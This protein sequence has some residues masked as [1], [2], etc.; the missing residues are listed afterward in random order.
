MRLL[1]L[2]LVAAITTAC[3]KEASVAAAIHAQFEQSGAR[4][5]DLASAVPAPWQRVCIIGPYMDN[6]QTRATLG[7]AWDSEQVSDIAGNEGK[8]L[9]AFVGDAGDV[10]F[11]TDY[12][13]RHGDFSNL[14]GKCHAR[15]HADFEYVARP[16]HGWPGLF[17]KTA[18]R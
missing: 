8:V 15:S 13:R 4:S 14:A 6:A 16:R 11:H 10:A 2:A 9:L 5:I 7:F 3:T 12:S 1:C 18:P 17:P